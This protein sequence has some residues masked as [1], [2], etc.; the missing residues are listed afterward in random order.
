MTRAIIIGD[1]HGCLN[2]FERLLDKLN[3]DPNVDQVFL[4]GDLVGK[5]PDSLGVIEKAIAVNAISVRG[6]HDDILIRHYQ[7][8]HLNDETVVPSPLN[9]EYLKIAGELKK[10][11]WD[12]L[13][14]MPLYYR[15]PQHNVLLV[16]AGVIPTSPMESQVEYL[17]GNY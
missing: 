11:H 14:A 9:E 15:I 8:Y 6:N 13:L 10:E 1:I 3:Y 2:E 7:K 4:V 16:H 5:G 12:Y 17:Q